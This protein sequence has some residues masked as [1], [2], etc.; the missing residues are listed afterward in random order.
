MMNNMGGEDDLPDLDAPEDVSGHRKHICSS[1]FWEWL[2]VAV[3]PSFQ[4]VYKI[5]V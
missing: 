3:G 2:T 4:K 5:T 1:I